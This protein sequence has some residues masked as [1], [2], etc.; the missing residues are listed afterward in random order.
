MTLSSP[1][2]SLVVCRTTQKRRERERDGEV[3]SDIELTGD[4]MG[5]MVN[6]KSNAIIL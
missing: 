1:S 6:A 3:I 4:S 2:V 5:E